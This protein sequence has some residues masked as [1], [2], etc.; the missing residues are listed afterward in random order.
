M[1]VL[2]KLKFLIVVF[3][4]HLIGDSLFW[5]QIVR[6]FNFKPVPNGLVG[7]NQIRQGGTLY[8]ERLIH[9]EQGDLELRSD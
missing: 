8:S 2:P 7:L 3:N 5:H 6:A 1:K 4:L 9:L